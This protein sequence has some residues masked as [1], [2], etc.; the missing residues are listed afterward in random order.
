MQVELLKFGQ[1]Q[2]NMGSVAALPSVQLG[3]QL[4]GSVPDIGA[5]W[6]AKLMVA[7]KDQVLRHLALTAYALHF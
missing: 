2:L 4:Q 7:D 3:V 1:Q 5:S 6:A